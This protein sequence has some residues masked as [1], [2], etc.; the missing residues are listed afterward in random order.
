M[1]KT[2]KHINI[3]F[4]FYMGVF[5]LLG[6][7]IFYVMGFQAIVLDKDPKNPRNRE[8]LSRRGRIYTRD[9]TS[10]A[11]SREEDGIYLRAYPEGQIY[12][13]MLGYVSD[14]YG[15]SGIEEK[16]DRYLGS[17]RKGRNFL[18]RVAR[19]RTDGEHIYL[20]IDQDIQREAYK[21]LSGCRGAIV[22]IN[23][24]TGEIL[25]MASS[26]AFDPQNLSKEWNNLVSNRNAPLFLRPVNSYYP[27]GSVLKLMTLASC[28]EKGKVKPN[29][30]L[31]CT[32][33]YPISYDQGTYYVHDAGSGSHGNI[34]AS[35]ALVYSCNI[36]FAQMGLHL[37]PK[38]FMKYAEE[39]GLTTN[40]EFP[41]VDPGSVCAFP[42]IEE[43]TDTQLAQAAFGQGRIALSPLQVAMMTSAF[44]TDG[45]IYR[46]QLVKSRTDG[47]G[48][49]LEKFRPKPWKTPISSD[50]ALQ[51]RNAMVDV[52]ERG[53]AT[54]A[55]IPGVKVAGK[56]G[57]AENPTGDHHAW[58]VSF[59]PAEN[60]EVL[61]VV[62]IENGGYGG[63]AAAPRAKFV[64]ERA[65]QKGK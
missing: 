18:H 52:V 42:D 8:E 22:A 34:T 11:F 16:F 40:P 7:Y 51:V 39:F 5:F 4:G 10:I 19:Y 46:P 48:K 53:T 29:T 31:S 41:L 17:P 38:D 3:V 6:L 28:Y 12:E 57:T 21:Q 43:L 2:G 49:I 63:V 60:P 47:K 37:G 45:K 25:A 56:T 35:D 20:T 26:P 61:V 36:A 65:L 44:A 32:G 62:I 15:K 54:G 14:V 58:F 33:R 27:P 9:G 23:P 13:P 50:T 30:F 55:R 59:A 24:Q 1:N 64:I